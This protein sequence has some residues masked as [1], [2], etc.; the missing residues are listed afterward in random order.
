MATT[1]T[2]ASPATANVPAGPRLTISSTA[3]S[4]AASPASDF[5]PFVMGSS[6]GL[7][8]AHLAH[9]LR[10][11]GRAGVLPRD[12]DVGD[13]R[14]HGSVVEDVRERGHAVGAWVLASARGVAA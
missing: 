10:G 6:L 12:A 8:H 5:S 2:V 14:G 7:Q 3:A 11:H 9:L 4:S 1:I 13:H